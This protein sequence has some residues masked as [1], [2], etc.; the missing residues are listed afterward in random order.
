MGTLKCTCDPNQNQ[1]H[2]QVIFHV[3]F[4][5][6]YH[7]PRSSRMC[8]QEES[9]QPTG[10]S[11]VALLCSHRANSS[12]PTMMICHQ[13]IE[14]IGQ[15]NIEVGEAPQTVGWQRTWRGLIDHGISR[16]PLIKFTTR[17]W[18]AWKK[19]DQRQSS[20]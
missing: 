13:T 5:K 16:G 7:F 20:P 9:Q 1:N 14:V 12:T 17:K 19:R 3:K 18:Q 4:Q 6:A 11:L 10:S 8:W 15:R 2:H